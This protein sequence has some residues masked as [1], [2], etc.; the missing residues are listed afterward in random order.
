MTDNDAASHHQFSSIEEVMGKFS[1]V[2]GKTF[3]EIDRTMRGHNAKNKGRLGQIVEE[4][5][6]GYGINSDKNPDIVAGGVP[7]EL[8]VTPLRHVRG[9]TVS[10]KERLV[11][12]IINYMSIVAEHFENSAC[13]NKAQRMLVVYY[14]DDRTDKVKQSPLDCEIEECTLM[15][16]PEEDLRI[17]RADWQKIHDTIASGHA[18]TLSESD[19]D[20]LAACTKGASKNTLRDA[21][22]PAGS[23]SPTIR[24]KQ[25]AFSLKASYMTATIRRL[26]AQRS[27]QERLA[28][29]ADQTL[30]SFVGSRMKPFI[31]MPLR[32]VATQLGVNT[33]NSAKSFNSLVALRMLGIQGKSVADV[34]QFEKANVTQLKTSLIYADGLPK[35]HMSFPAI[36]Q[37]QWNELANPAIEWEDSFVHDF[38]EENKFLI[39]VFG[40]DALP[41]ESPDKLDATIRGEFLWNMPEPD[42][43]TY[44]RPVWQRLHDVLVRGESFDYYRSGTDKKLPGASF[45]GVC[46]IRPHG[47]NSKDTIALPNGD[48]I[49]K[50]AFWLDRHY[51]GRIIK[52]NL[53]QTLH[54]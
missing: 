11:I 18:D 33:E 15:T 12:D 51:I 23:P 14:Y 1:A 34:E 39:T 16:F 9:G 7:Y 53:G 52:E 4:S 13:W 20:Y 2:E 50:Q 22:A 48:V 24:A 31:G 19:T 37:E 32:N 35:E 25:R 43:E 10:A 27:T 44:V 40:I 30:D 41:K 26:I 49:P 38:F 8:K 46:H 3:R 47:A 5:V 28:L 54:E 29:T 42:I 21:P 45:N 6:L 36:T 17:I